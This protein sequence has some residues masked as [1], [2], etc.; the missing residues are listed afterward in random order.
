MSAN[1]NIYIDRPIYLERAKPFLGKDLIK[2]FTGQR[3]TGKSYML[4]QVEGLIRK[5]YPE[6]KI[7][8]ID[9]DIHDFDSI[10]DSND[11]YTYLESQKTG[12]KLTFLLIDEVQEIEGFE[13]VLRSLM[14]KGG[15]DIWC[16]GSNASMLSGELATLLSGR[17][18]EIR[19]H[20]LCYTEFLLFFNIED[21]QESLL[22]FLK[23]GGL[24]YLINLPQDERVI[25]DYLKSINS[26]VLLKDVVS[27]FQ[28]RN[29]SFLEN[30]V[31]YLADITG[32]LVSA[33]SISDYLKSQRVAISSSVISN[34]LS[35]LVSAYYLNKVSRSDIRG[36][37]IFE[38]GE[39]Y[40]FEDL[41]LRHALIGYNPLHINQMIENCVFQHLNIQ[42]YKIC[43][44]KS[45]V[46]EIDF[47]AERQGAK[48]YVQC[49]YLLSDEETR[50][51]EFGNLLEIKDNFPKMVISMDPVAGGMYKGIPHYHL[52]DFLKLFF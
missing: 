21:S 11:L 24:P 28:I 1:K 18:I 13:K 23:Y 48:L 38:I 14:V 3:R 37:K 19:I 43:I 36:K 39:K 9:K 45:G 12:D 25:F 7:I 32:N 27:R 42:G 33:K 5:E 10:R 50:K 22:R 30:L 49:A 47:I 17:F 26:T 52:R 34:Y 40:F 2:I 8:F 16:T 46:K 15:Y 29:V 44:M 4:Y 51:R 31:R 41:G 6:S 20:G 35:Y